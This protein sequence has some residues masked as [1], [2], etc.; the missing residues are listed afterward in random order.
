MSVIAI[1]VMRAFDS[2]GIILSVRFGV[3]NLYGEGAG[4]VFLSL[5]TNSLRC[6]YL[7]LGN[8]ASS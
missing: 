5:G 8:P 2:C 1:T 7:D 4:S 6:I 3:V